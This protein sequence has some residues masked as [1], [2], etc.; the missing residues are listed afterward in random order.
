MTEYG[1][2][3]GPAQCRPQNGLTIRL[4]SEGDVD[5]LVHSLPMAPAQSGT[6]GSR[7]N[8]KFQGLGPGQHA[9]LKRQQFAA[10]LW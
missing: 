8:A 7:A 2:R 1:I 6:H 3:P 10:I 9:V 5:T 4:T